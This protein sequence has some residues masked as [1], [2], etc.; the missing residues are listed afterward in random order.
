MNKLILVAAGGLAREVLAIEAALGRFDQILL[1]DDDPALWG[2]TI[3]GRP[4]V[5][6]VDLVLEFE[7]YHV[8][9]CAGRGSRRRSIVER[10]LSMGIHRDRD[11]GGLPLPVTE[12]LTD[13][14]LILPVFH[15]MSESEQARV[16]DALRAAARP[17]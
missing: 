6:G 7:D 13:N 16:V 2:R 14:T 8:L 1:V 3:G 12:R 9:V 5:G 15:Q 17:A 11:T 10:L 4:V